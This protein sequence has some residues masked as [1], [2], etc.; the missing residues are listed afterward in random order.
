M[1]A[2]ERS[3]MPFKKARSCLYCSAIFSCRITSLDEIGFGKSVVVDFLLDFEA[4]MEIFLNG[5]ASFDLPE[6]AGVFG[7]EVLLTVVF[8][9]PTTAIASFG[10][11]MV[12]AFSST[13]L[14]CVFSA[15][16]GDASAVKS[17]AVETSSFV[18][19]IFWG[20]T[21]ASAFSAAC[22]SRFPS[23]KALE[24]LATGFPS[25][26]F[27]GTSTWLSDFVLESFTVASRDVLGVEKLGTITG[28]VVFFGFDGAPTVFPL[29]AWGFGDLKGTLPM[30]FN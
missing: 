4:L 25:L 20:A 5:D 3:V 11:T 18:R 7:F 23:P 1:N 12:A 8:V 21:V 22:R 6:S 17:I 26:G 28:F 13:G 16:F 9:W 19:A 24:I 30:L 29:L 15:G 14:C 10:V 2:M 27:V